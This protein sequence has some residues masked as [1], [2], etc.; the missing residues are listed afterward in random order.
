M[1]RTTAGSRVSARRRIA[2]A[3]HRIDGNGFGALDDQPAAGINGH[4]AINGGILACAAVSGGGSTIAAQTRCVEFQ[5]APSPAVV[6]PC[7]CGGTVTQV[8]TCAAQQRKG[9]LARAEFDDGAVG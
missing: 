3:L 6:L 9:A 5:G 2:V 8:D 7:H 4:V 1:I